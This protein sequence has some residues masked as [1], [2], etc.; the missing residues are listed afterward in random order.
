MPPD[1]PT[2]TDTDTA[3]DTADDAVATTR[4]VSAPPSSPTAVNAL[5]EVSV[6]LNAIVVVCAPT[7]PAPATSHQPN[8]APNAAAS[9]DLFTAPPSRSPPGQTTRPEAK[10]H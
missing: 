1:A 5:L 4:T 8:A 6:K 7:G 9:A 3:E 10:K 2:V